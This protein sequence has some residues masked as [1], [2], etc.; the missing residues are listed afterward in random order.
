MMAAVTI[1]PGVQTRDMYKGVG[2]AV[3]GRPRK[4]LLL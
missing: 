2:C 1:T 4:W 3:L